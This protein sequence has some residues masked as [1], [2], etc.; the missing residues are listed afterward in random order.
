[1]VYHN[2]EHFHLKVIIISISLCKYQLLALNTTNCLFTM[3]LIFEHNDIFQPHFLQTIMFLSTNFF[4]LSLSG[5]DSLIKRVAK[6]LLFTTQSYSIL[7]IS[8]VQFSGSVVPNSSRPHQPQKPGLL[9]QHQLP[10][11]AQTHL[12]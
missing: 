8:S 3:S 10:K 6:C 12:H 4:L 9:V 5:L 1:M 11:S 2:T 7:L